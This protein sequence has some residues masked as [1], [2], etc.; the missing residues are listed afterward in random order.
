V[1][2]IEPK[3]ARCGQVLLIRSGN[4]L[5]FL[6]NF[7]SAQR[8]NVSLLM[9]VRIITAEHKKERRSGWRY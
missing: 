3:P 7:S 8:V 4:S 9:R 6:F 2:Q 1:P 5:L